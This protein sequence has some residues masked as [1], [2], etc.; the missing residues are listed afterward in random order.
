M[1]PRQSRIV[2]AVRVSDTDFADDQPLTTNTVAEAEKL[3]Q[4]IERTAAT[5]GLQMNEGKTNFMPAHDSEHRKPWS[6]KN[7]ESEH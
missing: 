4:G 5:A 3:T 7:T 1:K 2:K 6:P